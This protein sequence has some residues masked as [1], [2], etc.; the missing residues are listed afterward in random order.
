MYSYFACAEHD[1]SRPAVAN[2]SSRIANLPECMQNACMPSI[3]IRNVPAETH[4]ELAA[5]AAASGRS[6]QEYL[7]AELIRL[8][9][10]PDMSAWLE[11]LR[12]DKKLL[13][14]T[15]ST[16]DILRARDAGR[17]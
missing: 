1:E 7:R 15:V 12:E 2:Q 17:R 9:S 11:G 14:S 8:A 3:T 10:R 13:H 16:A 4:E 6:L 5:R